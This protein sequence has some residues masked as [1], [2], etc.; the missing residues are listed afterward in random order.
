MITAAPHHELAYHNQGD[1]VGGLG[2]E[3][4]YPLGGKPGGAGPGRSQRVASRSLLNPLA[5]PVDSLACT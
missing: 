3:G 5:S 1:A 2:T 4:Q